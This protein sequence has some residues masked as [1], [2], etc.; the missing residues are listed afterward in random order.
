MVPTQYLM[1]ETPVVVTDTT[2][3]NYQQFGQ[4]FDAIGATVSINLLEYTIYL[5]MYFYKD[6]KRNLGSIR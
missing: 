5:L 1:G 2:S 6:N 3:Y 4:L